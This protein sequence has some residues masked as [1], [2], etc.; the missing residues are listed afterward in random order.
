MRPLFDQDR[1]L[2]QGIVLCL[3]RADE[4]VDKPTPWFKH[5]AA[6]SLARTSNTSRDINSGTS[7]LDAIINLCSDVLLIASSASSTSTSHSSIAGPLPSPTSSA[8]D[9]AAATPV[10]FNHKHA[11][12][13]LTHLHPLL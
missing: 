5:R 2:T 11:L 1:E 13:F 12:V 3:R 10:H 8:V 4:P 9:E 7:I 6:I